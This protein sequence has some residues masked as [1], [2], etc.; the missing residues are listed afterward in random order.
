[1]ERIIV[2]NLMK[3]LDI[4]NISF[5][6]QHGLSR[7]HSC[8]SQL[9]SLFQDLASCTTQTDMLIMDFSKTFDKVPHK[10]LSYKQKPV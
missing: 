3:H 4:Q 2:S 10:R 1:M 5:P 9:L 6:L 7:N 8:E